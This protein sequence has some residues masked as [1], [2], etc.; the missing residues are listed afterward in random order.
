MAC[1]LW[2][3]VLACVVRFGCGLATFQEPMTVTKEQIAVVLDTRHKP[4]TKKT[5]KPHK[6]TVKPQKYGHT[7]NKHGET[8][9]IT[10]NP[11]KTCS[12]RKKKKHGQITKRRSKPQRLQETTVTNVWF[13]YFDV[14]CRCCVCV[15]CGHVANTHGDVLNVHTEALRMDTR[16]GH[17]QFC[18][19]KNH[20]RRVIAGTRG[21]PEKQKK[22]THLRFEKTSNTARS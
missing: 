15:V 14:R 2:F 16:E 1:G 6:T 7:T 13:F 3:V 11:Q 21:S 9:K 10:V 12:I 22:L 4:T 20:P 17:R 5:V 19:P 18:S 8:I